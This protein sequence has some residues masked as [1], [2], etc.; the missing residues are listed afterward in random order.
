MC[1]EACRESLEDYCKDQKG[2]EVSPPKQLC[3]DLPPSPEEES[4][5]WEACRES[6]EDRC[7]DQ[8]GREVNYPKQMCLDLPPSPDSPEE[9]QQ[10]EA[11]FIKAAPALTS[12][13]SGPAGHKEGHTLASKD[14][15]SALHSLLSKNTPQVRLPNFPTSVD[16]LAICSQGACKKGN[17]EKW[18]QGVKK[19]APCSLQ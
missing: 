18:V 12:R 9:A 15:S 2:R 10:T 11:D 5:C 16:M 4:M 7:K 8:K 1:W 13:G 17:H 19:A 3:L 6:L 14:K